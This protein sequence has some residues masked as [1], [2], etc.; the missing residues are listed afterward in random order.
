MVYFLHVFKMNCPP[1]AL[2]NLLSV[3]V[4]QFLTRAVTLL[5][6]HVRL[7]VKLDIKLHVQ[8]SALQ[9]TIY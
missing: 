5:R 1:R 4:N 7:D 6:L 3:F 2:M 9:L 8:V